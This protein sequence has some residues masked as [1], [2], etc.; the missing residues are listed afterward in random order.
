MKDLFGLAGRFA[1][2]P[3]IADTYTYR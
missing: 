3:Y 2:F 1:G